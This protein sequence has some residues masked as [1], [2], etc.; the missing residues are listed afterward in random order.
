ME[1]KSL[2]IEEKQILVLLLC[3]TINDWVKQQYQRYST[4]YNTVLIP[5]QSEGIDKL[6]SSWK[7]WTISDEKCLQNGFKFMH[8]KKRRLPVTSWDKAFYYLHLN[9]TT[10]LDHVWFIEHDVYIHEPQC[11]CDL[12]KKN[13]QVDFL[14]AHRIRSKEDHPEWVHWKAGEV[15]KRHEIKDLN[16]CLNVICCMSLPMISECLK[17]R[18]KQKSFIFHE[19]FFAS[20]ATHLNLN[21]LTLNIP[22]IRVAPYSQVAIKKNIQKGNT[23]VIVHPFKTNKA[24]SF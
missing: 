1:K 13:P 20:I 4:T 19:V 5:H 23:P 21:I 15:L 6:P 12:L 24:I 22:T 18:E 3:T 17:I 2:Q 10:T 14:T 7:V 16:K 11:L 8:S 9:E